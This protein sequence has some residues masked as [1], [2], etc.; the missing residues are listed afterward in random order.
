[1]FPVLSSKAILAPMSGVTNVAFRHLCKSL[2]AGLTVTEFASSAAIVRKNQKTFDMIKVADNES[3]CAVQLFGNDHEELLEAAKIVAKDFDI[4]D[5]NCGCP[6]YK[7]I[8]TKS[9]SELLKE[10]DKIRDIV[11]L[12]TENISKPVTVKIRTGIDDKHINAA[13]RSPRVR[14]R[15]RPGPRP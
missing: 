13:W 5:I 15:S 7:V 10:P 2:G 8:R 1:M 6:A 3:P 14:A 12:L 9:G 11:R 4:I